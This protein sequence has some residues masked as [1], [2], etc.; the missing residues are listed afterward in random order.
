MFPELL[1]QRYAGACSQLPAKIKTKF[2]S[3][4]AIYLLQQKQPTKKTVKETSST[5]AFLKTCENEA[6]VKDV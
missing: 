5:L 4:K 6:K 3:I 1:E 2:S